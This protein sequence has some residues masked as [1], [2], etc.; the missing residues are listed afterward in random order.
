M[1]ETVLTGVCDSFPDV[2]KFKTF[3]ILG[4]CIAGFLLGLPMTTRVSQYRAA[5]RENVSSGLSTRAYAV[6]QNRA[7]GLILRI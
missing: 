7:R 3:I 1:V 6:R 4:I 5:T 2:R